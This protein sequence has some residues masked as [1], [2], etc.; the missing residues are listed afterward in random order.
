[1]FQKSHR[2]MVRSQLKVGGIFVPPNW[3]QSAWQ[4]LLA[5]SFSSC[6][7]NSDPFPCTY[8]LIH[9]LQGNLTLGFDQPHG[10][11][12]MCSPAQSLV[13]IRSTVRPSLNVQIMFVHSGRSLYARATYLNLMTVLGDSANA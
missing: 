8:F 3:P 1:M 6:H 4:V 9:S 11:N 7:C 10:Q 2:E 13:L 5:L 12:R